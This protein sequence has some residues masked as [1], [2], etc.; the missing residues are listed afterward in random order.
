LPPPGG[1]RGHG[2]AHQGKHCIFLLVSH[3]DFSQV[4]FA[5]TSAM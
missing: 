3:S 4:A 2:N 5:D 1:T